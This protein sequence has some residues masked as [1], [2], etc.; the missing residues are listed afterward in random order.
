ME[1][2]AGLDAALIRAVI[3]IHAVG[4]VGL[5]IPTT[6]PIFLAL[7]PYHLLTMFGILIFS[8]TGKLSKVLFLA[9]IL[10]ILGYI[11]EY[12]GVHTE[13]LFGKYAYGPTLGFSVAGIPLVMGINWFALIYAAGIVLST[14]LENLLLRILIGAAL[15]VLLDVLIEPIAIKFNYWHW[16]EGIVPILNYVCWFIVASMFLGIFELFRFQSQNRLTLVFLITQ[17][18]F[19]ALLNFVI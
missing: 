2:S 7:V 17:F 18:V 4:F 1:R 9:L 13:I 19:F 16:N 3:I 6:Q 8:Y 14:K 12:I 11:A 10:F 15:L 5:A